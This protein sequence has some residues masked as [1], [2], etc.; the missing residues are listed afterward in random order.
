MEAE[1]LLGEISQLKARLSLPDKAQLDQRDEKAIQ[2]NELYES[3]S[4]R[5]RQREEE[6]SR[7]QAN[8]G[9]PRREEFFLEQ[10]RKLQNELAERNQELQQ[11]DPCLASVK[12]GNEAQDKEQLDQLNVD[13]LQLA[14]RRDQ[15]LSII[16]E[17]AQLQINLIDPFAAQKGM[18]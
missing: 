15:L 8:L 5:L 16:D 9:K 13:L 18:Y 11:M 17:Q 2:R 10:N 12:F 4:R 3:K 1:Q 7:I 14:A 6:L